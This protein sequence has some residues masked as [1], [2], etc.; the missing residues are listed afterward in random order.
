[1]LIF[2]TTFIENANSVNQINELAESILS[3]T[4]QTNLLALNAAIEAAR[5]DES[6]KGFSVVAD[7]IRKLAERSKIT[8]TEIQQIATLIISSVKSLSD[9]S[10]NMLGFVNYKVKEDYENLL[11]ISDNYQNDAKLV[12]EISSS[13][14]TSIKDLLENII[15]MNYAINEVSSASLKSTED[16]TSVVNEVNEAS[17]GIF[18][19][20]KN[21]S[22]LSD[23]TNTLVSKVNMFKV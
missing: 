7:E 1:M 2:I 4:E 11:S 13:L 18:R 9:N 6:G 17:E 20:S 12:K 10:S 5:A 14:D 19:V 21:V 23:C 3:I 22:D 15:N 8:V 16:I